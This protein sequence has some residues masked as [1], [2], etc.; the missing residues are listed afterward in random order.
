MLADLI[1]QLGPWSWVI[2][3]LILLGVEILAP[4]NVFVWFGLAALVTGAIAFFTDFG[5]QTDALIFVVLAV[6]LVF[7][8]RRYFASRSSSSEQP[9]LNQRAARQ[10]GS[11]HVLAEPIVDGQGRIRIDDTNWRVI[12]PDMPSGTRVTVVAADGAVLTVAAADR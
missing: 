10:I 5:W 7:A 12:G 1:R 6:V 8:G 4:G 2:A 3:G 11:T 9:L